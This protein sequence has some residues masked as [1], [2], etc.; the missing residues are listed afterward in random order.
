[1]ILSEFH[2]LQGEHFVIPVVLKTTYYAE[3]GP[4]ILAAVSL[5][6][7]EK[8]A[9]LGTF[10]KI[11]VG[12]PVRGPQF[13]QATYTAPPMPHG[14]AGAYRSMSQRVFWTGTFACITGGLH[15]HTN[16]KKGGEE[17]SQHL[18]TI[19]GHQVYGHRELSHRHCY[20]KMPIFYCAT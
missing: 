13:S 17:L 16:S 5:S 19:S 9:T 4:T 10:F 15:L 1:M 2:A 7:I 6:R 20:Y 3:F 11:L 18:R 12:P 14:G 8:V